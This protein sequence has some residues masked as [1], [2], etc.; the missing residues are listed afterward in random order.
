MEEHGGSAALTAGH[1]RRL[2][3]AGVPAA[4]GQLVQG[5][6]EHL[7]RLLEDEDLLRRVRTKWG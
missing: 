1:L 2:A 7:A 6:A 5:R 4:E 3:C